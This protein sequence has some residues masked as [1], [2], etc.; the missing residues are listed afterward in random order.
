MRIVAEVFP[1]YVLLAAL[2]GWYA[3]AGAPALRREPRTGGWRYVAGAVAFTV[4]L[5][6]VA[7]VGAVMLCLL[8]PHIWALLPLRPAV[9][10]SVLA[11]VATAVAML[12]DGAA[13]PRVLV[14]F[15]IGLVMAVALGIWI[16]RIIE[17]SRQRASSA[18]R[19]AASPRIAGRLPRLR[20]SGCARQRYGGPGGS[21]P[22]R[23]ISFTIR[24]LR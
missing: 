12:A 2:C 8:Y 3:A 5:F 16:T 11:L 20:A 18:R 14:I 21:P 24:E 4:A 6:A 22:S 19:P 13:P 7:P 1:S 23:A 9:A 10:A 15:G 17:Q